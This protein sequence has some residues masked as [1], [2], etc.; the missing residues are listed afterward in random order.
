ME[1]I[2]NLYGKRAYANIEDGEVR[3]SSEGER[4][5]KR[6]W[7]TQHVQ[8]QG[9]GSGSGSGSGNGHRRRSRRGNGS[10]GNGR[11]NQPSP[12]EGP[13]ARLLGP[14]VSDTESKR[15]LQE[16]LN[17]Y[18]RMYADEKRLREQSEAECQRLRGEMS[19]LATR[20]DNMKAQ[21]KEQDPTQYQHTIDRM[22]QELHQTRSE[23]D[24]I[25]TNYSNLQN[26]YFEIDRM[27]IDSRTQVHRLLVA[28]ENVDALKDQWQRKEDLLRREI[29]EVRGESAD[30]RRDL[31][32]ER[33]VPVRALDDV[34]R[35]REDLEREKRLRRLADEKIAELTLNATKRTTNIGSQTAIS[36]Q[37]AAKERELETKFTKEKEDLI[38]QHQQE[39]REFERTKVDL[40]RAAADARKAVD[41]HAADATMWENKYTKLLDKS[42][43]LKEKHDATVQLAKEYKE[44]VDSTVPPTKG[45]KGKKKADG[46]GS[47]SLPSAKRIQKESA[48]RPAVIDA[49]ASAV[50]VTPNTTTGLPV[51][52]PGMYPIPQ[53]S[54]S[55]QASS[56][57]AQPALQANSQPHRP[58]APVPPHQTAAV[59]PA[60]GS[61]S[62]SPAVPPARPLKTAPPS[63]TTRAANPAA[64]SAPPSMHENPLSIFKR[65]SNPMHSPVSSQAALTPASR[66]PAAAPPT[67]AKV[68]RPPPPISRGLSFARS[69][70]PMEPDPEEMRRRKLFL[71][72][73]DEK[74]I[75]E[76]ESPR[77]RKP[78]PID[79]DPD[80]GEARP[81]AAMVSSAV[82]LKF[83]QDDGMEVDELQR[84]DA[85][86]DDEEQMWN[87]MKAEIMGSR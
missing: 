66:K 87:Q 40:E 22:G 25:R 59:P 57:T 24:T 63:Q 64:P 44:L 78:T 47:K 61:T 4:D 43:K 67:A 69:A 23:L 51:Q 41:D 13:N 11:G 9:G 46:T 35:L 20:V 52:Q 39:I 36:L 33:S 38:S 18:S 3:E 85:D 10:G 14:H 75:V 7:G 12:F 16:Q 21:L 70:A 45:G 81:D 60:P 83:E 31:A 1:S 15:G 26:S 2:F 6:S 84:D 34:K 73:E 65:K 79:L 42:R 28:Q 53:P 76:E 48:P 5:Q 62:Q 30:L 68:L 55:M 32:R 37:V 82:K 8:G 77:R 58:P 17:T 71:D 72:E 50:A 49:P 74:P 29:R 27:H 54:T 19:E 86:V 56:S 80:D